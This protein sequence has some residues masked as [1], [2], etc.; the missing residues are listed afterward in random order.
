MAVSDQTLRLRS[1]VS[2]H[3]VR[4][5]IEHDLRNAC[6]S[7]VTDLRPIRSKDGVHVYRCVCD[8][9]PAVVKHFERQEH[10]REIVNYRVLTRLGVP[11]VRPLALG[12]ST[13]VL[14]DLSVSG[15]WRLGVAEDLNDTDV[16]RALAHW[17]FALHESG[18]AA[19]ELDGMYFEYDALTEANL[20]ALCERLPEGS[21]V[22]R[23]LARRLERLGELLAAVPLT[24]TYNDFFWTNLAVRRD[25][26]A[27]LMFDHNLLGKGFR[28][29]DLRN[30]GSF[31]PTAHAALLEEYDR[32]FA[33]R[34]GRV[35][36]DECRVEA[37][38]DE[39]LAPVTSL[40]VAYGRSELPSWARPA[41]REATDGTLLNKAKRLLGP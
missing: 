9:A 14:E 17:Y 28:S 5:L 33:A 37:E 41:I 32:S 38:L 40:I 1:G 18:P 20:S 29:S 15:E 3:T 36:V 6:G 12:H 31:S 30:L 27:A 39:V 13:I 34:H 11:T 23:L 24:L 25:K 10:R 22:F 4:E 7:E 2:P 19:P 21:A 16:A 8:G 26:Q 35:R